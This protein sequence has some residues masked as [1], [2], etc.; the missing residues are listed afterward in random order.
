MC[1]P[2]I[3]ASSKPIKFCFSM[4]I[5]LPRPLPCPTG[6]MILLSLSLNRLGLCQGHFSVFAPAGTVVG[7]RWKQRRRREER[8]WP[9]TISLETRG[10]PAWATA[11]HYEKWH[12]PLLRIM[13]ARRRRHGLDTHVDTDEKEKRTQKVAYKDR[14]T[15]RHIKMPWDKHRQKRMDSQ[16][17]AHKT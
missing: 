11:C 12:H 14:N 5:S 17:S 6:S 3:H 7:G 16:M 4:P 13:R 10:H 9:D 8:C 1:Q 2:L 15:L